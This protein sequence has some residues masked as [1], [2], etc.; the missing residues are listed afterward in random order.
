MAS[1][2]GT[3]NSLRSS[4]P[5]ARHTEP[6]PNR[7]SNHNCNTNSSARCARSGHAAYGI[8]AQKEQID[9]LAT[10]GELFAPS[11]LSAV[12]G[13]FGLPA[14]G[15][16]LS[17]SRKTKAAKIFCRLRSTHTCMA[18]RGAEASKLGPP[19]YIA[20]QTF[21]GYFD[22][23]FYIIVYTDNNDYRFIPTVPSVPS[24]VLNRPPTRS[25]CRAGGHLPHTSAGPTNIDKL[26]PTHHPKILVLPPA[27]LVELVGTCLILRQGPPTSTS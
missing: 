5:P 3:L 10:L 20:I 18:S 15:S 7:N 13:S 22:N 1:S 21:P 24:V 19:L 11:S 4:A 2:Q 25:S 26:T 16:Y 12:F 17:K 27:L 6:S 14:L 8:H 23:R 9:L